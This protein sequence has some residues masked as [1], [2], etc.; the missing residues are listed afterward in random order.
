MALVKI[1]QSVC[2]RQPMSRIV[3]G[4]MF[5]HP[6]SSVNAVCRGVKKVQTKG[7]FSLEK[8]LIIENVWRTQISIQSFKVQLSRSSK[9]LSN[10]LRKETFKSLLRLM[11]GGVGLKFDLCFLILFSNL[12]KG[13]SSFQNHKINKSFQ[14]YNI[15]NDILCQQQTIIQPFIHLTNQNQSMNFLRCLLILLLFMLKIW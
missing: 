9:T 4:H 8:M 5:E 7:T 14:N 12:I 10:K 6:L 15:D 2:G 1:A 13:C 11:K 3:Y